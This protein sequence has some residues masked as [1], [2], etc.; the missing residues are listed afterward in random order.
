MA[1]QFEKHARTFGGLT[2]VSRVTGLVRDAALASVFGVSAYTDAFNFAFQIP[3]LFRRLFGEG[4]ISAAFVP[5]YTELVRDDPERA[6]RYAGLMLAFLAAILW[7]IV[8]LGEVFILSMWWG[9]PEVEYTLGP[10]TTAGGVVLPT[11]SARYTRLAY[12]LAAIMLPYMPL[13]CLL[14]VGGSAL[15][16]HGRF[17]PSAAS[18]IVLNL[19]MIAATLG[20]YPLVVAGSVDAATHLRVLAAAVLL[21][22]VIQVGWTFA[23]LRRIRLSFAPRD[24]EARA[25]VRA[26]LL[27]AGPMML[28]LGVIQINIVVDG[29][30]ASWPSLFGP[31]ILG[32]DYPLA[33]GAMT[34]LTNAAR[35]YEFPLGVFGISIATAIFPQLARLNNDPVEFAATVRRGLRLTVFVGLPASVGLMLVGREAVGVLFQRGAFTADDT[36]RVAWVLL[37]FAPAIWAYQSIHIL[38]RAFYARKE[39][40]TPV[41]I[42]VSMVALNVLLNLALIF[43]PL[44]EAGLAWS[45]SICAMVQAVVLARALSRQVPGVVG[46]DVAAGVLRSAAAA[47]AMGAAV[48]A[49]GR[50]LPD[51]GDT[52]SMLIALVV[53]VAVGAL[54]FGAVAVALR[55]DE[56]HWAAGRRLA[57]LRR[58]QR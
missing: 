7:G 27:A 17:G 43:T 8:V 3:N 29:L 31:T 46:R 23:I 53:K 52:R 9:A 34:A 58:L 14:A 1:E 5:R 56:L 38:T 30:I 10:A 44:R 20:L 45:T 40:M 54:V 51:G 41:R 26:T 25:S 49:V 24:A 13:V 11:V 22:G 32:F 28:G 47:I 55:M 6:R 37:G 15:Q 35:L 4:A 48:L 42:A 57:F 18:P 16:T 2:L 33:E 21:A 50:F 19:L 36:A 39:P 12:E